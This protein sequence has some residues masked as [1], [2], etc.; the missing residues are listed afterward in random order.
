M[1]MAG[2]LT[3]SFNRSVEQFTD[4]PSVSDDTG[5]A[6]D[7]DGDDDE[8]EDDD[9]DLNSDV[10]AALLDGNSEDGQG[11]DDGNDSWEDIDIQEE[12]L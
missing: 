4:N 5:S 11:N 1:R 6:T 7:N 8:E 12:N 2:S 3:V 9:I 10:V